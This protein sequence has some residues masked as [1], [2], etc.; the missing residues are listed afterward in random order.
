M[1]PKIPKS[2]TYLDIKEIKLIKKMGLELLQNKY[3][4]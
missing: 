1:L 3:V 2:V 4:T